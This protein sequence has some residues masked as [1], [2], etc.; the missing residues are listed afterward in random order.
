M[1]AF[2][3]LDCATIVFLR[4]NVEFVSRPRFNNFYFFFMSARRFFSY[5]WYTLERCHFK[6]MYEGQL[7]IVI[8][9]NV[10][11]QYF[12]W[13]FEGIENETKDS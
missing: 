6:T 1:F 4:N 3:Q 13:I 9:I 10:N 8:I 12:S 11:D 2:A 5:K 7:L